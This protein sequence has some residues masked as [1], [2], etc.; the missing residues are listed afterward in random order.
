MG[1]DITIINDRIFDNRFKREFSEDVHNT[2]SFN[3]M[4]ASNEDYI[5][6]EV[7]EDDPSLS[8]GAFRTKISQMKNSVF[9]TNY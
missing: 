1:K 2:F 8:I 6:I 5:T 4:I 7:V 9:F 3:V